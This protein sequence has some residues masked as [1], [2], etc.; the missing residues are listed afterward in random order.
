MAKKRSKKKSNANS[1]GGV[2]QS[3]AR[4]TQ[5]RISLAFGLVLTFAMVASL[6]L[7]LLTQ[8]F[9]NSHNNTIQPTPSAAPT[10]PPPPAPEEIS[11][12][13]TYLHPSGLFTVALPDGWEPG[14][15]NTTATEA[16][17][18]LENPDVQ[19]IIELRMIEPQ[20]DFA[21]AA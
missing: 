17:A 19:S 10:L 13:E 15:S 11:F 12:D 6:I 14:N 21:D 2:Y 5:Q 3:S 4:K 20:E 1:G 18:Q 8:G 7:P 16:Q 9:A